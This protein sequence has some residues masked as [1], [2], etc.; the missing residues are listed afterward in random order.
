M[1]LCENTRGFHENPVKIL[2]ILLEPCENTRGF[3]KK[4]SQN[5]S[6]IHK[7]HFKTLWVLR[8]KNMKKLGVCMK[9]I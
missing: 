4:V 6:S 2:A 9:I 7:I 3:S 1:D 8:G 5:T